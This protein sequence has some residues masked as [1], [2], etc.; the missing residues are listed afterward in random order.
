[1]ESKMG[2]PKIADTARKVRESVYLDPDVLKWLKERSYKRE[3]SI[4]SLINVIVKKE[5]SRESAK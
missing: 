1:M 2:R 5:M 3:S 4:S